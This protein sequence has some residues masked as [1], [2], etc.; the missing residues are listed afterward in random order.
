MEFDN[1]IVPVEICQLDAFLLRDLFGVTGGHMFV[2]SPS[3]QKMF[4]LAYSLGHNICAV[5]R[6]IGPFQSALSASLQ[7]SAIGYCPLTASLSTQKQFLGGGVVKNKPYS[8]KLILLHHIDSN[9]M[10]F[11]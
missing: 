9:I 4:I 7:D 10:E 2:Q 6:I 11:T 3:R 1:K 5:Q 8:S